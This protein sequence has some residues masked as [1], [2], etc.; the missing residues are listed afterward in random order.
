M[1]RCYDE[2]DRDPARYA[3]TS[4]GTAFDGLTKAD[5]WQHDAGGQDAAGDWSPHELSFPAH[6]VAPQ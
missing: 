3:F 2:L 1:R 4:V 5:P 6:P